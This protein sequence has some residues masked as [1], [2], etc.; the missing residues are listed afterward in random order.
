MATYQKTHPWLTFNVNLRGAPP[1]LWRALG[2]AASK[3]QHLAGV[4]LKPEI[5]R[6]L[7]Q[8]YLAKGA[9]ATTAIEGNT[10]SEKEALDIVQNKSALPKSQEYLRTELLN[11]VEASND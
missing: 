8:V 7:H 11:I 4:P 9:L 10:L 6:L 2:E 5:A 1:R 3:C